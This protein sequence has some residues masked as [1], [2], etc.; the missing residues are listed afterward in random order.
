MNAVVFTFLPLVT[1][2]CANCH[3]D[4]LLSASVAPWYKKKM[5]KQP[6]QPLPR[7]LVT[8]EKKSGLPFGANKASLPVHLRPQENLAPK[9]MV[10]TLAVFDTE[11]LHKCVQ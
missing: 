5:L 2:K 9:K 6:A 11:H 8:T 1:G 7:D 3:A 4:V 10:G